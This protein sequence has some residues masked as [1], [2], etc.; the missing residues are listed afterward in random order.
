MP[1]IAF[2]DEELNR[3]IEEKISNNTIEEKEEY[4]EHEFLSS[5]LRVGLKIK[6]LEMLTYIDVMKILYSFISTNKSESNA[7][8]KIKAATQ[9]DIDRLLG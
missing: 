9:K 5:C 8:R 4:P 7:K 3:K 2:V 1:Q 6:D